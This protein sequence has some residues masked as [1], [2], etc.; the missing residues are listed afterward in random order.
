[1]RVRRAAWVSAPPLNCGVRRQIM[2]ERTITLH[3]PADRVLHL[4]FEPW[5]HGLAF[6][7][8]SVVEL[9]ATSQESGELELDAT[10]ER[11]AVY[12]WPGSTLRVLVD[13]Q[14]VEH[15]STPVPTGLTREKL[16]ILF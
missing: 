12:G 16:S 4:W 11:T 3:A 9:V 6:P 2:H 15:F 13:G 1:M 8:G 10:P 14:V 7:A 5:A